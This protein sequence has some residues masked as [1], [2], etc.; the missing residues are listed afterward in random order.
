MAGQVLQ[1]GPAVR[2]NC[3]VRVA[4]LAGPKVGFLPLMLCGLLIAHTLPSHV[5]N[6]NP[7]PSNARWSPPQ[8]GAAHGA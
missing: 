4:Q 6:K 5:P 1:A 8:G 3:G 2:S 7:P